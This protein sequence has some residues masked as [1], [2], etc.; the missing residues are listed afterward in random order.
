MLRNTFIH[1]PGI[2]PRRERGLWERGILDWDRFLAAETA[3]E[4]LPRALRSQTDLVRQSVEALCAGD[5]TFFGARLPGAETW[6]LYPDFAQ[7][8]LFLD[9]E[10]TGLSAAWDQ[11]TVI[12]TYSDA[13]PKLFVQGANLQEFPDY[14]AQFP[15]LITFNGSQ[16]DI[17]FLRAHFP[18]ARLDQAH[19]DLRFVLASLGYRGGLKAVEKTL[20]VD[21]PETVKEVDGFEAVWLWHRYRRGDRGALERL[22]LYNLADVV[23]MVRLVEIGVEHKLRATAFPQA[24]QPPSAVRAIPGPEELD[25][26]AGRYVAA[27]G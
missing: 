27:L 18:H 22:L 2:G 12:G 1:L 5:A 17:P 21:R 24:A 16:F 6:R 20:G 3:G 9:I 23:N 11:V 26:W 14:V 25:A 19:I 13:G 10:T 8:A 15:L 4:S 7:R